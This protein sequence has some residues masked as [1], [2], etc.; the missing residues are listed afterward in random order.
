MSLFVLSMCASAQE[1]GV[2]ELVEALAAADGFRREAAAYRL[3]RLGGE[4]S[5]AV[6]PLLEAL[7]AKHPDVVWWPVGSDVGEERVF[8]PSVHATVA[9]AL[10]RIAPDLP[11]VAPAHAW[12]LRSA[13]EATR[14]ASA[15][16]LGA[17]GPAAS[18]HRDGLLACLGDD[19][20][21]V[22]REVVTALS[23]IGIDETVRERLG[24]IAEHPDAV[25]RAVVAAALRAP[26]RRGRR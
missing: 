2:A 19:S 24:G 23:R 17:A 7:T 3:G 18:A 14:I 20:P 25:V 1:T 4:G 11:A 8:T 10:V 16:A 26:M 6:E 9:D 5:A 12:R 21:A 13:D 22:V 15:A